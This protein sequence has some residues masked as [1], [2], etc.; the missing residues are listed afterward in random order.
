M[1]APRVEIRIIE[2]IRALAVRTYTALL[3]RRTDHDLDCEIETHV[4]LLVRE[5][6]RRGMKP[7]EALRCRCWQAPP[8]A[9]PFHNRAV[10]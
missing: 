2:Q 4:D 9:W 7:E 5:N 8:S 1:D 3:G 6:L 10:S